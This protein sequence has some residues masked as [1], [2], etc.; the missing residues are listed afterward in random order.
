MS[1]EPSPHAPPTEATER[2]HTRDAWRFL[3]LMAFVAMLGDVSYEGARSISGRYVS[4]LGASALAV[5]IT[6]GLGELAGSALRVWTGHLADRTRAYWPLTL[7]GYAM[8]LLA[9][10]TLALCNA[11]QAAAALVVLERIGK[12]IRSPARSVLLSH[13]AERLGPGKTFGLDELLD[14]IGAV[15]GPLLLAGAMWLRADEPDLARYRLAF[16]VTLLPVIANLALALFART[17][18]PD[19]SRL[20]PST[21]TTSPVTDV[22]RLRLYLVGI[23]LLGAAF[24]DWALMAVH[25]GRSGLL[26]EAW[27]PGLYAIAMGVDGAAA[28]A[29]GHAYDRAGLRVLAVAA[30][31]LALG[32]LLVFSVMGLP[33][34]VAG[35]V[36]WAIAL[37]G[38]ESVAKAAITTLVPKPERGAAYGRFYGVLGVSWW[39]GSVVLGLTY[40]HSPILCGVVSAALAVLAAI[41]FVRVGVSPAVS[42]TGTGP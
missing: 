26:D 6:A 33:A 19:P 40:E 27:V 24:A 5:S 10:P 37:G 41:V 20:A 7:L 39:V 16:V 21:S 11:W 17:R 36:L 2:E 1:R 8:N 31:A 4:L 30:V 14:Q 38:L 23:A 34:L 42:T 25:V 22:K 9:I 12:A 18:F 28:L 29:F 3:V 13:A 32:V 15:S 35:V